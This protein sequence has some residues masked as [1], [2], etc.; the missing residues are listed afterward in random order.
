MGASR[1]GKTE[2]ARSL[3]PHFYFN[4]YFN[5]EQLSFESK[6]AVFDDF[7]DWSTFKQYKQWL[8]AQRQFVVTDKY[9]R[10][11]D[12]LWGRPSVV[13][14]NVDPAFKDFDWVKKNCFVYFM[15]DNERFY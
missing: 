11:R 2:W 6:Y 8:G 12:F 4:G 3:G 9:R 5:M 14:S 15:S 10:K 13:L 7:E 1:T